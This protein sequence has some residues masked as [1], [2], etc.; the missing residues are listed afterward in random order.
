MLSLRRS[1]LRTL[2]VGPGR[3]RLVI[4]NA[5]FDVR[6]YTLRKGDTLESIAKKRNV[7]VE[8]IL[9]INPDCKPDNVAEGQTILLPANKLSNRD[10][11]I[12]SGIG[13][14][15]R[16]Y[17]VRAG[18]TLSEVLSKRGISTAEFLAL[19]PGVDI[20]SIKD[21]QVVKLPIDKFTVRE[22]E[23]LIGSGIL[24]PEFFTAAKNPFVIGLGGFNY[25]RV[26]NDPQNSHALLSHVHL[27]LIMWRRRPLLSLPRF[28]AVSRT[29]SLFDAV[30]LVCGFVMAWQRF[31]SDPDMQATD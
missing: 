17:P 20:A 11:E 9:G 2:S 25:S 26:L 4:R 21:N 22:R 18:E 19:N 6:P 23:M 24:P 5:A 12:L 29:I 28:C 7:T 27:R 16:L 8:Q 13:T 10:K 31:H 3:A 15:Y 1:P 30:M 14:T